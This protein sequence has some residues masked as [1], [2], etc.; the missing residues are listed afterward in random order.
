MK[1]YAITTCALALLGCAG[2]T[3]VSES[4]KQESDT[5]PAWKRSCEEYAQAPVT[6]EYQDA[7]GGGAV[8]YRTEGNAQGLRERAE[9]IARFHN[10]ATAKL[11]ELHDL[12]SIPHRASVEPIEGG[13][14][15]VLVPKHMQRRDLEEL[16]RHVQQDVFIMQR[17]GC[18]S[19]QEAL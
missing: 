14:K 1:R 3:R 12:Y 19:G 16:R 18:E 5:L 8:L 15:L 2:T 4:P 13:A 9:E 10:N 11:G 7:S 6:I 17:H